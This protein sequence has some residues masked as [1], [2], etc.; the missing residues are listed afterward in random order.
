MLKH[1]LTSQM[2]CMDQGISY[3]I[4]DKLIAGMTVKVGRECVLL[5]EAYKEAERNGD[6]DGEEEHADGEEE[7]T[8]GTD[9]SDTVGTDESDTV[10]TDESDGGEEEQVN[11]FW[12]V[13]KG[14]SKS[15][16]KGVSLDRGQWKCTWRGRTIGRYCTKA[17]A[18]D[19]ILDESLVVID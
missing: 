1:C 11:P 4:M 8:V 7:D 17:E 6:A 5:L 12:I 9:E 19:R 13:A 18:C 15:G 3:A 10:G 16:Y 2:G 14:K